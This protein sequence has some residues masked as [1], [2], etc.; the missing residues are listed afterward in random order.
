MWTEL[1]LGNIGAAQCVNDPC[2]H[3]IAHGVLNA[4]G[5]LH[6]LLQGTEFS[7]VAMSEVLSS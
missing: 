6:Q 4:S 1:L 5:H 2:A 3:I 7:G